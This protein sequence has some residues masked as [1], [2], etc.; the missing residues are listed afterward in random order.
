MKKYK[1]HLIIV[2][3]GIMLF[4]SACSKTKDNKSDIQ[5]AAAKPVKNVIEATGTVN[6]N[7]VKNIV[8]DLPMGAQAK[9]EKLLVKEGQRVEKNDKLVELDLSDFKALIT[10]KSKII[11]ADKLL[12]KDMATQNQ[13]DVQS[14]KI[15]AEE[16]EL[17]ALKEKLN[18]SYFNGN[19]IISD[20]D[21]GVVFDI[22][23]K[24]GDVIG[25]QQTLLS[26]MDLKS[27]Y[28]NAN[29]DEEFIKDVKEGSNV[30]VIPKFDSTLKLSGKVTKILNKAAKQNGETTI[31]VEI[32][33]ENSEKLLPNYGVDIEISKN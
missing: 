22:G 20:I 19:S 33:V 8:I 9:L 13:K 5:P 16:A 25:T 2:I 7:I 10:Q 23:Y 29:I 4:T 15:A 24:V 3:A 11:E 12:K 6:C 1:S 28:I 26:L 18:K 14:L 17:N 32:S 31:P 30:V 27:I 21:N